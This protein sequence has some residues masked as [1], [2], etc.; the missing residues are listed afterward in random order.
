M[1]RPCMPSRGTDSGNPFHNTRS[2]FAPIGILSFCLGWLFPFISRRCQGSREKKFMERNVLP[3]ALARVGEIGSHGGS[4][5]GALCP[6][7]TCRFKSGPRTPLPLL[8]YERRNSQRV[9]IR[10][11]S[12]TGSCRPS[13][14]H[15]GHRTQ[16][17]HRP[18]V[19]CKGRSAE[20]R[21]QPK[22]NSQRRC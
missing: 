9:P 1:L 8:I 19:S 16:A 21:R 15:R 22:F 11:N 4:A 12:E 13:Y 6:S 14:V 18:V 5:L 3:Y 2:N 10:S 20:V 17:G 7:R